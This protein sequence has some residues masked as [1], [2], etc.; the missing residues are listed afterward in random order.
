MTAK[1]YAQTLAKLLA[2]LTAPASV[3]K[4]QHSVGR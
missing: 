1:H 3:E 2:L 4:P